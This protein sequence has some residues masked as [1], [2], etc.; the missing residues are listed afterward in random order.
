MPDQFNK[1][2]MNN[3]RSVFESGMI[4]PKISNDSGNGLTVTGMLKND[5]DLKNH[6]K[7][8]GVKM[9]KIKP[10]FESDVNLPGP[11]NAYVNVANDIGEESDPYAN[12]SSSYEPSGESDSNSE[13][14]DEIHKKKVKHLK[15]KIV[16]EFEKGKIEETVKRRRSK[17]ANKQLWKRSVNKNLRLC[18]KEYVNRS[19][20]KMSKKEPKKVDCSKCRFK[21]QEN[22]PENQREVICQEYYDLA[23][24]QRQKIYLSSLMQNV[25]VARKRNSPK[26]K[27]RA[28][29]WQYFLKNA[30]GT[31]ERVCEK[32]FCGTFAV[33]HR[34]IETTS[35]S[36][37][38]TGLFVGYDKRIDT[39]PPNSTSDEVKA[40]V[41]Q[42]IN[43]FPRVES[44]Y[45]RRDSKKNYL[46]SDLNILIMYILYENDFCLQNKIQ[47][48]SQYVY[49]KIFHEFDP[50]L[51]FYLPKKDQC[52]QCNAYNDAKDRTGTLEED[53]IKHKQR[54]KEAMKMKEDDKKRSAEEKGISFRS[55]SFDLQAI[56]SVPHAGD[57]QIFY[58][59][60][61]N[62][63]N[64]TIYDAS[65]RDGYCYVWDETHGN[66]GSIEIGTCIL[67]YLFSLPETVSHV[68]SF[69]DTCG[70]QNRNKFVA[71]A[72]LFAVNNID[73][74]HT[75]DLKF[76]E[77]GHSHLEADSMHATIDRAKRHKKIYSTREWCLLISTAR[78]KPRL[79][80]V[81]YL[82]YSDFYD[83]KLLANDTIINT[84]INIKKR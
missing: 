5:V 47:P 81:K 15:R 51:A 68:A 80:V 19:G 22:I 72:M 43:S 35:K 8:A 4:K 40:L 42:H 73:H 11:S 67:K 33:S 66:K 18:G 14:N 70:G 23:D 20:K 31:R 3:D 32:F 58:K 59:H 77:S 38:D 2:E 61:L 74:L 39:H 60:K 78:L 62:V 17:K 83:L 65:N 6:D 64:F 1:V 36:F 9:D 79:Y 44:H 25:P 52:F 48:V 49:Q 71:A 84:S 12:S 37:S 82:Q 24:Y 63:Y 29:S 53:H 55:I 27:N 69:S 76:M 75:I 16:L 34:V 56:L 26:T 10:I 28:A 50:S 30:N 41:K 54:E 45:C 57:S 46:S 7:Y 13:S 21:C